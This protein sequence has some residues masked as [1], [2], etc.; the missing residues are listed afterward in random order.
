M[1]KKVTGGLRNLHDKNFVICDL[2]KLLVL[3]KPWGMRWEQHTVWKEVTKIANK[4]SV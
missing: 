1:T 2:H 3:I 4:I